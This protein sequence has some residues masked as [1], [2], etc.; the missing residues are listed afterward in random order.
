MMFVTSW[1]TGN[2]AVSLPFSDHCEPIFKSFQHSDALL[3]EVI[4]C[5]EE[6]KMKYIEFRSPGTKYPID[7]QEFRTDLRHLL[8]LKG[9]EVELFNFFSENTK[10]NIK[11]ATK[12]KLSLKIKNDYSGIKIFYKMHCQTRK[13]HGLPPQPFVFFEN[14]YKNI[15]SKGTGDI[16]FAMNDS[17]YIA[18]AIYFKFGKK[19]LYKFGASITDNNELRGNFFVMW[20]A[21]KKYLSE[22]FEE[23]DFGRTELN[24]EGLQRFKRGWNTDE[25]FIYTSR[26]SVKGKIFLTTSTK[27]D[28]I[29]NLIFSHSPIFLLKLVG[30]SLY[31]HIG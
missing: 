8:Q 12:Q 19:L 11:K 18:S 6:K 4:G 10:R 21:I 26:Y 23:F 31:K 9:N 5:C 27:T 30:N 20:E 24:H 7:A 14:I 22:G 17:S 25:F 3:K 15:I 28:G 2:R 1:L 13:R 16:L 29:H